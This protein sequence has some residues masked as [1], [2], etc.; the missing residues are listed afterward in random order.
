[1]RSWTHEATPE[2]VQA[3]IPVAGI[4]LIVLKEKMRELFGLLKTKHNTTTNSL[5][6]DVEDRIGFE[7]YR[8]MSRE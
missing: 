7:L 4:A 2:R 3:I 5:A 6:K 1:M 8:L